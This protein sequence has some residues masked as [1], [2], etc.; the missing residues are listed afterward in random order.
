MFRKK[1]ASEVLTNKSALREK[2]EYFRFPSVKADSLVQSE[3]MIGTL[4][5]R[6]SEANGLRAPLATNRSASMERLMSTTS[7]SI[8]SDFPKCA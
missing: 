5:G 3:L 7:K 4:S 6:A 8:P 1:M 2:S